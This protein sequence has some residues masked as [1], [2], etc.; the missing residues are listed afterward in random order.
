MALR[1][2]H[3]EYV[4]LGGRGDKVIDDDAI[5]GTAATRLQ[6]A[7]VIA[8]TMTTVTTE[9]DRRTYAEEKEAKNAHETADAG[10]ASSAPI[11]LYLASGGDGDRHADTMTEDNKRAGEPSDESESA[12]A[13]D[14]SSK[15]TDARAYPSDL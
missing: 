1:R 14:A 2:D 9:S 5:D 4:D 13:D 3:N 15:R 12:A 7:A 8:T 11:L 6:E 10:D